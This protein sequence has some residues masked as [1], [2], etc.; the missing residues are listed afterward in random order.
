VNRPLSFN[1]V[2]KLFEGHGCFF[3]FNEKTKHL[4][5]WRGS[6]NDYRHWT[7]HAHKGRKDHFERQVI[8]TA[9]RRLG[10][11]EIADEEFYAP[12]G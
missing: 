12:L 2:K 1:E 8:A 3:E 4:K 7:Q 10:F 9:R 5:V 11:A 6:G